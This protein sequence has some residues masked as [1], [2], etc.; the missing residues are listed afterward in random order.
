MLICNGSTGDLVHPPCYAN[1]AVLLYRII[2]FIDATFPYFMVGV[3][4]M[5]FCAALILMFVFPLG[6]L[7]LIFI[8]LLTITVAGLGSK[9]LSAIERRLAA[10]FAHNEPSPHHLEQGGEHQESD[11]NVFIDDRSGPSRA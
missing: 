7:A 3:V 2:R 10:R 5:E 11:F 4:I 6:S 9:C 8:G 1:R